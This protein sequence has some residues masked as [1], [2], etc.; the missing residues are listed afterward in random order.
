MPAPRAARWPWAPGPARHVGL[1]WGEP[2]AGGGALTVP[3][4]VRRPRLARGHNP[5]VSPVSPAPRGSGLGLGQE[6]LL[7]SSPGIPPSAVPG[8]LDRSGPCLSPLTSAR[9]PAYGG[10]LPAHGGPLPSGRRVRARAQCRL[11]PDPQSGGAPHERGPVSASPTP[12]TTP[13]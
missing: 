11:C 10:A 13:Q 1:G 3:W 4:A 7:C 12:Q 9:H 6:R 5:T 8:A 2:E